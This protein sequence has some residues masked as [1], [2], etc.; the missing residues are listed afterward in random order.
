MMTR[1]FAL[2]AAIFG[3]DDEFQQE[4]LQKTIAS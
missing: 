3:Y 2:S 4:T 1:G